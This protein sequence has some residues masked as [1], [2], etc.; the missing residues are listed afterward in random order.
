MG[1]LHLPLAYLLEPAARALSRYMETRRV[2]LCAAT[3]QLGNLG[4]SLSS[5]SL[6]SH[7]QHEKLGNVIPRCPEQPPVSKWGCVSGRTRA[8][9]GVREM[10][11]NCPSST[12]SLGRG[13]EGL[14]TRNQQQHGCDRRK[15]GA[16]PICLSRWRLAV[17]ALDE[18]QV[19]VPPACRLP[20]PASSLLP[21][22]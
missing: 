1:G 6:L 22:H 13:R 12:R 14:G 19:I 20:S 2:L 21:P 4:R 9:W 11:S 8:S 5:L 10:L 3:L 17:C 18:V 16:E 15:L 7:L